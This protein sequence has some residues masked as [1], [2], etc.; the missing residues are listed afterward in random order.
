MPLLG[1]ENRRGFSL[2]HVRR[3]KATTDL[4]RP[5]AALGTTP[6]RLLVREHGGSFLIGLETIAGLRLQLVE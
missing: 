5:V 6:D 1:V 3:S 4:V 2:P